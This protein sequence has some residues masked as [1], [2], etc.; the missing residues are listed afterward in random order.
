MATLATRNH[1]MASVPAAHC[2]ATDRRRQG[3]Q[4]VATSMPTDGGEGETCSTPSF[5]DMQGE[6]S[7]PSAQLQR[8]S[9]FPAR[10][11]AARRLPVFDL[12]VLA[13]G[14]I[15]EAGTLMG[16]AACGGRVQGPRAA[17]R[18]CGGPPAAHR[19]SFRAVHVEKLADGV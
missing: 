5:G 2:T 15:P 19:A 13:P 9:D 14:R 3:L 16:R 12:Q 17:A 4:A 7:T 1:E 11:A 10:S 8:S 18:T 6:P